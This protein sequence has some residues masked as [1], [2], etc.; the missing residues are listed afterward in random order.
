MTSKDAG[1]TALRIAV[2]KGPLSYRDT[3]TLQEVRF[4]LDMID[5]LNDDLAVCEGR[6]S[7]GAHNK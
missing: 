5:N 3:Y 4:L 6:R 1:L 2:G 7:K